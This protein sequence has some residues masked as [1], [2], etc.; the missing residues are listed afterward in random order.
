M[1]KLLGILVLGLLVSCS[2]SE[3]DLEKKS[4]MIEVCAD[5][6]FVDRKADHEDL[7]SDVV[8]P[9]DKPLIE[10]LEN[11]EYEDMFSRCEKYLQQNP[12]TFKEKYLGKDNE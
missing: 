10:K 4:K 3:T 12:I 11:Y 2:D 6:E 7:F 9:S 5:R 1:K 8:S